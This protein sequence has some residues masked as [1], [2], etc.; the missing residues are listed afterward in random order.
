[1]R[2]IF[3][4]ECDYS[5]VRAIADSLPQD[6]FIYTISNV[7]RPFLTVQG[8]KCVITNNAIIILYGANIGA[9]YYDEGYYLKGGVADN[10]PNGKGIL[11][12]PHGVSVETQFTNGN[13]GNTGIIRMPGM[14]VRAELNPWSHSAACY[15]IP[16]VRDSTSRGI[17]HLVKKVH[18]VRVNGES[19]L[20]NPRLLEY[21][22]SFN[23]SQTSL[24]LEL[25]V[26]Q[27][28]PS[29]YRLDPRVR[30][31]FAVDTVYISEQ[32]P[33]LYSSMLRLMAGEIDCWNGLVQQKS[34]QPA[35]IEIV[36]VL[37][38][39]CPI[40]SFHF[41]S[42]SSLIQINNNDPTHSREFVFA[43]CPFSLENELDAKTLRLK[44]SG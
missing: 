37:S 9:I 6:G 40:K 17:G 27:Q 14:E 18:E 31:T 12:Y 29:F 32:Q 7:L 13:S 44:C 24:S 11:Y 39:L 22:M 21:L 30:S 43:S 4:M 3:V 16:F 28:I 23:L 38:E 20:L 15:I 26:S 2:F 19:I 33:D 5:N 41:T 25:P 1:M 10:V 35:S 34:E 36:N 8:K 42:I